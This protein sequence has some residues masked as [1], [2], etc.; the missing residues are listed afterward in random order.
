MVE[1]LM[2]RKI[3]ERGFHENLRVSRTFGYLVSTFLFMEGALKAYDF[4][5]ISGKYGLESIPSTLFN[6]P[7]WL[8]RGSQAAVKTIISGAIRRRRGL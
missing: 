2:H 1:S 6:Y 4:N 5:C 8:H 7:V 3:P